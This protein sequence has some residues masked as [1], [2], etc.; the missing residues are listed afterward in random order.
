MVILTLKIL[1]LNEKVGYHFCHVILL[2]WLRQKVVPYTKY[3]VKYISNYECF[4]QKLSRPLEK[5]A[6]DPQV[7]NHCC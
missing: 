4:Y 2:F 7:E 6:N 1:I 3:T 5:K